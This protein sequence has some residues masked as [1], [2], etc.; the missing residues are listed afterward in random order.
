MG[1]GRLGF[2][3]SIEN[4]RGAA[5]S[6]EAETAIALCEAAVELGDHDLVYVSDS[7][8]S[9]FVSYGGPQVS[10]DSCT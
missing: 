9:I 4:P 1:A 6:P 5:G 10:A 2:A 7:R 8:G 3:T